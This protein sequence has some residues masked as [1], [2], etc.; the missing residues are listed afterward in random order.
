MDCNKDKRIHQ[1]NKLCD[2]TLE[3]NDIFPISVLDA[4]FDKKNGNSL[5][6]ILYQFNNIYITFQGSAAA[7]RKM[8][9]FELRRKGVI[10]SYKNMYDEAITEKLIQDNNI[11][12]DIIALDTSWVTIDNLSLSGDISISADGYWII[13]GE[14]TNIE[15][16][17][18]QGIP[19]NTPYI[20]YDESLN[21]LQYSYDNINWTTCS[22]YISAWFKFTGTTGSSQADNIGKIQISRD[23]GATWSDL[24]GEFTNSLHIKG[25]VATVGALPS[26]AVQGDIYGVGP[27]YDPSD[28]EQTNPIYQ[29]YVKDNTGWINNGRF[30]SISAG[31]VQ[32]LGDSETEVISQKTISQ[33]IYNMGGYNN[34]LD[35]VQGV[36]L[37][38]GDLSVIETRITSS[39]FSVKN[40]DIR[41][42]TPTG[43][44]L[45][46]IARYSLSFTFIDTITINISN[47]YLLPKG[48]AYRICLTKENLTDNILPSDA[49][50]ILVGYSYNIA[51]LISGLNN[52]DRGLNNVDGRISALGFP[53]IYQGGLSQGTVYDQDNRVHT[54]FLLPKKTIIIETFEDIRI[55]LYEYYNSDYVY[56]GVSPNM[57]TTRVKLTPDNIY[58]VVFCKSNLADSITPDEAFSNMVITFDD[59]IVQLSDKVEAISNL[60]PMIELFQGYISQN[61]GVLVNLPSRVSTGYINALMEEATL[62][63]SGKYK[64]RTVNRYFE[65]KTH[66]TQIVDASSLSEYNFPKGYL[67]RVTIYDS[68]DLDAA[69]TPE[70]VSP[71]VEFSDTPIIVNTVLSLEDKINRITT[72]N[73][74]ID[75]F[76]DGYNI[77]NYYNIV[78]SVSNGKYNL[79]PGWT[80]ALKDSRVFSFQD[81]CVKYDV[82]VTPEQGIIY[83]ATEVTQAVAAPNYGSCGA[84]DLVNKVMYI[85]PP[86]LYRD[87][88]T[89]DLGAALKSIPLTNV[90]SQCNRYF[91]EFGK[92]NREVEIS[93]TNY[94]TGVKQTLTQADATNRSVAGSGY[95]TPKIASDTPISINSISVGIKTDVDILFLGDSISDGR[96][97][98]LQDSWSYK[99]ANYF[100]DNYIICARSGGRIEQVTKFINNWL[101]VINPKYTIVSIGINGGNTVAL[102]DSLYNSL[103]DKTIPIINSIYNAASSFTNITPSDW[104]TYNAKILSLPC[105]H[106]RFDIASSANKYNPTWGDLDSNYTL[107]DNVH[108]TAQGH[109]LLYNRALIDLND[110]K[111]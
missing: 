80:N 40:T 11:S 18:S 78:G 9:P 46:T 21:K 19:G 39:L 15:A 74:L 59:T 45:R 63:M 83:I 72:V 29:L 50:G 31:V 70:L 90:D 69:I 17:G 5:K 14:K 35:F 32:E 6:S 102:F 57:V 43:V 48:Y 110:I 51:K 20:R 42:K 64:I 26:T 106:V 60:T 93:I 52:V 98:P 71:F 99:L 10:I 109:L 77:S 75:D 53:N 49:V 62:S 87:A 56:T 47:D 86:T 81:Y 65:D 103:K 33:S 66:D 44:F 73:P 111:V 3:R 37:P 79:P 34:T 1:L 55:R 12:D 104:D 61:K 107:T 38:S 82:N 92:K 89:P 22:D 101:D 97:I 105:R 54:S 88:N 28:T 8:L 25:Y 41:L 96:N 27:T 108:P 100:T 67:Y 94:Y 24:S 91:I 16:K 13:N 23:N 84:I 30:T 68:T 58:K 85:L 4:I 36:I 2:E 7:T 76:K 95:D